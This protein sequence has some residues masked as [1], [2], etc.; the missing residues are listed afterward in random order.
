MKNIFTIACFMFF[1][2]SSYLHAQEKQTGTISG[3]LTDTT[4]KQ[5]LRAAY[6]DI[7]SSKDS[8]IVLRQLSQADGS[9]SMGNIPFSSYILRISYLGYDTVIRK[10]TV[11]AVHYYHITWQA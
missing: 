10:C 4:N 5:V 9:F 7:L 2:A 6:I 3:K 8:T 1:A 11:D